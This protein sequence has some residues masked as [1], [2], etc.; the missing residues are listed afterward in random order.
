MAD[1][2]VDV[3]FFFCPDHSIQTAFEF[4][5]H[6]VTSLLCVFVTAADLDFLQ[7]I[8]F[9]FSQPAAL[10]FLGLGPCHKFR[11]SLRNSITITLAAIQMHYHG[12]RGSF[13]GSDNVGIIQRRCRIF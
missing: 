11:S 4:I 1:R 2:T 5:F 10:C 12:N 6:I 8:L 13:C 3:T 9:D 7:H